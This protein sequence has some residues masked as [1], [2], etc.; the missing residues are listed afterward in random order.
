MKFV[1][2]GILLFQ[3]IACSEKPPVLES[4]HGYTMGTSYT[5][6]WP[7][8]GDEPQA[9]VIKQQIEFL[10]KVINQ[11]MSTYQADSELSQFNALDA[12]N[13]MVVSQALSGLIQ[14]SMALN[15]LTDGYFDISVGPIVNLWGFGPDK[16][17]ESMPSEQQMEAAKSKVGLSAISV[18]GTLLRKSQQRY[19]DL[20]AIAKGYAVDQV[21]EIL[22][23]HE[24]EHYLVEIGGEMRVR[25]RKSSELA[26]KVAV[27]KPDESQRAVQKIFSLTDAAMATSGD[28]RNYFEMDGE[29][30]SHTIDPFTAKPVKHSLAS[31]TIIDETCAQADALAT[32]MLVMGAEKAKAFSEKHQI[33]AYLIERTVEGYQE[34]TSTAFKRWQTM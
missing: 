21:A 18:E 34:Y 12:P 7:M 22:E 20:S 10:L 11:Q 13:K 2:L 25:G 8:Q 6:K 33:R 26:W 4:V 32:A 9:P 17:P 14:Q 24:I 3:I 15:T 5:V 30:Y 23:S 16:Q 29:K 27:E 1:L 19:L 31:V 28:Y